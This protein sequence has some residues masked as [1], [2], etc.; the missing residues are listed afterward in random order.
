MSKVSDKPEFVTDVNM[1]ELYQKG[2]GMWEM[3]EQI[4]K[5]NQINISE[6]R[7]QMI[8]Y[9]KQAV[10]YWQQAAEQGYAKAQ[11]QL[12]YYY[13]NYGRNDNKNKKAFE[14]CS[15]AAEQG[16]APAQYYL[17]YCYGYGSGVLQNFK[18]SGYW[19]EKAAESGM[20]SAAAILGDRYSRFK[21]R[22]YKKAI[23]WYTKALE[24]GYQAECDLGRCY[25]KLGDFDNAVKWYI[26]GA[27]KDFLGNTAYHLAELYETG[28]G[29]PKDLKKAI[30]WYRVSA[31]LGSPAADLWLKENGF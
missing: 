6:S 28:V 16:Y 17:G 2:M 21:S 19:Y 13:Y 7:K 9:E 25:E 1:E 24:L 31:K 10:E 3:S 11:Y 29:I 12:G 26:K 27:E 22:N 8:F 14:W 30:E 18:M 15:K 4:R 5:S 23:Y 20:G